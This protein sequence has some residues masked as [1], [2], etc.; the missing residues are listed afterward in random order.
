[1]DAGDGE[2]GKQRNL[3]DYLTVCR[4]KVAR[5]EGAAGPAGGSD[6]PAKSPAGGKICRAIPPENRMK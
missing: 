5:R 1:M 6:G 4:R 3:A 2:R